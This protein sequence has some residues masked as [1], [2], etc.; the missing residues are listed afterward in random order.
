MNKCVTRIRTMLYYWCINVVILYWK[1]QS[2]Y[3]WATFIVFIVLWVSLWTVY[4]LLL[5]FSL[6]HWEPLVCRIWCYVHFA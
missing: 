4:M 1:L 2:L 3:F 6:D 5:G